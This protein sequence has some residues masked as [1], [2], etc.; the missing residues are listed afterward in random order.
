MAYLRQLARSPRSVHSAAQLTE[1]IRRD[2]VSAGEARVRAVLRRMPAFTE[3]YRGR[4]QVGGTAGVT[5]AADV[6]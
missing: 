1:T 4:F 2:H 6:R 5:V 3:P